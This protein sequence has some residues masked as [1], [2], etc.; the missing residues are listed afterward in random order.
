MHPEAQSVETWLKQTAGDDA[1]RLEFA[2]TLIENKR[3]LDFGCGNG[4]FLLRARDVAAEV[5]GIEPESRLRPHFAAHGLKVWD[6]LSAVTDTFDVITLFHVLEHLPDP[7]Q[8]LAVL[9]KILRP[10]GQLLIEVPNADDALLTLYSSEP[11]SRFTYWS[12]HIF[13]FNA[14]T[15]AKVCAQAG[16]RVNCVKHIQRYPLSNHLHW[17]ARGQPGGHQRWHFLDS[18]QLHD[19]YEKQLA[20]LAATDTIMASIGPGTP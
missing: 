1:R 13:L 11:F 6:K 7:R 8:V 5:A 20:S 19:A 14:V 10:S 3:V 18:A 16:F 12:C 9:G 15:L 4:G 2:R 17:L